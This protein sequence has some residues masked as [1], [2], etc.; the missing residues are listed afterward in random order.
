MTS[1]TVRLERRVADRIPRMDSNALLFVETRPGATFAL[2]FLLGLLLACGYALLARH[3]PP[4]RSRILAFLG[5][6]VAC[7]A[8]L[9]W[10][11][12]RHELRLDF[13]RRQVQQTY[14]NLGLGRERI[15][16]FTAFQTVQVEHRSE[17]PGTHSRYALSLLG[18]ELRFELR[19]YDDAAEAE[20]S[21]RVLAGAGGWRALRSGYRLSIG[22]PVTEGL[23]AGEFHRVQTPSGRQALAIDLQR[24]VRVQVQPGEQSPIEPLAP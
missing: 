14:R 16:P 7:T 18:P 5:V 24:W 19:V 13:E 2:V 4:T 6:L 23:A 9:A 21:A 10:A 8:A 12:Q 17:G 3:W 20:R 1:F 11:L 15:H 22:G